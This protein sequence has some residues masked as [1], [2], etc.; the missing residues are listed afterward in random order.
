MIDLHTHSRVS[1][2]SDLPEEVVE[3]AAAAGCR[4]LALTDHDSLDGLAAAGAAAQRLGI[5]LVPGCEVSCATA[6]GTA[7]VL[8]YFVE[9]G[10]GPLRA[11][12]ARLR[13]DR[14]IR[15][16]ELLARCAALGLPVTEAEVVA[17]AGGTGIGRPHVAAV[18]VRNGAAGSIEEAFERF[19][20]KG[21]PAY[22]P[23]ARVTVGH[24]AGLAN[25]SG[26][27]AVLA[28]PLSLGLEGHAL[29]AAVA[30]YAAEGLA[31][32]ECHYGRYDP[33]VRDRLV[34]L[35]ER[36]GLVATG[37][38]DYHGTYKPDLF[39][40][41]GT[42]DLIVPDQVLDALDERRARAANRGTA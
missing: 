4:A 18:L 38:S 2:G 34:D 14:E 27:L 25:A 7:H 26:A 36:H 9:H 30:G 28:H 24:V 6:V 37:G 1:D 41:T 12:L 22:V 42:G 19:L 21:A 16:A 32:L 3:K 35:A 40:G 20:G 10:E 29:D 8:C 33:A 15:N 31:G 11:E 13:A 39:V 5:R 23:K 17:E